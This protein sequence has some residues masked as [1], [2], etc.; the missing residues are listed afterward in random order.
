[1]KSNIFFITLI[2]ILIILSGC[3]SIKVQ[4]LNISQPLSYIC[5]RNNPKVTV[6]GFLSVV[7]NRFKHNGI[8]TKVFNTNLP[9]DCQ[10]ILTYTA[11]RSWDI[12]TYLSH[13]ELR[14]EDKDGE[15][16]A[17]AEYHLA[18]GGGLSL[19]KFDSV[20]KKMNPIID[21]LL[22]KDN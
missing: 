22:A 1:M 20:D 5:I 11:L 13:A 7:R 10:V 3:T 2:P 19:K 21:E 8:S 12:V 17:Y 16:I 15:Q 6:P 18:G 9:D 14:L 4:P